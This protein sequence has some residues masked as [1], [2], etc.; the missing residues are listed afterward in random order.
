MSPFAPRN[1]VLSR[2]ERRQATRTVALALPPTVKSNRLYRTRQIR[3]VSQSFV[4]RR[5]WGRERQFVT[6]R[7]A[8]RVIPLRLLPAGRSARIAQV[9]GHPDHVH[10]LEEFGLRGGTEIE[11]FRPGNP[12]ILR[13]AGNKICLRSDELLSVMVEPTAA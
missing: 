6:P 2:S 9:F 10:R 1:G 3:T 8:H 4:A 13:L 5:P 7:P 11:M 12:C